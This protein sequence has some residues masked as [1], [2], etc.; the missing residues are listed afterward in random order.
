MHY[1]LSADYCMTGFSLTYGGTES[2]MLLVGM[3]V[4][5]TP[6]RVLVACGV[7]ALLRG[8]FEEVP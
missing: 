2:A 6:V 3:T 8:Y 7:S 4:T 1:T 5:F